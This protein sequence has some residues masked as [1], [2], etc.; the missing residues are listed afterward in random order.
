MLQVSCF[1]HLRVMIIIFF[2]G[3]FCLAE[4]MLGPYSSIFH[5]HGLW[6]LVRSKGSLF[7]IRRGGKVNSCS[8]SY[9]IV[10]LLIR[11]FNR[12]NMIYG[13]KNGNFNTCIPFRDDNISRGDGIPWRI[14]WGSAPNGTGMGT[15]T[16]MK[17]YSWNLT[18][19]GWGKHSLPRP[20]SHFYI[21]VHICVI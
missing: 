17:S 16:R 10:W 6:Q 7:C 9:L 18:G 5:P 21:Y 12:P 3:A 20:H 11:E 4:N 19:R 1:G 14:P 15:G 2:F 13:M 8:L